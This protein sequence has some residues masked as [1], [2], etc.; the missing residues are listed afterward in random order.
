MAD[1]SHPRL[2]KDFLTIEHVNAQSLL[3]N[4]DEVKQ[5]IH[6]RDVDVCH[7]DAVCSRVYQLKYLKCGAVVRSH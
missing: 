7:N 4:L 6:S 5:I 1:S 3:S 2:A